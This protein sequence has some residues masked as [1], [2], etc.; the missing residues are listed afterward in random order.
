MVVVAVVAVVAVA[1]AAVVAA[2]AA[3]VVE[4][5]IVV[6]VVAVCMGYCFLL[7]SKGHPFRRANWPT[8]A[9]QHTSQ[10]PTNK[11]H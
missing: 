10:P 9:S 4:L 1:I 6:I 11:K 2:A 3:A 8:R 7:E 5:V